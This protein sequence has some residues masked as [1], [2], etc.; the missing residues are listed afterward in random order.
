MNIHARRIPACIV[1][2]HTAFLCAVAPQTLFANHNAHLVK[3]IIIIGCRYHRLCCKIVISVICIRIVARPAFRTVRITGIR[4][5][6]IRNCL[7]IKTA[8][9]HQVYHLF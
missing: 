9:I 3:K 7:R 2:N 1:I 6:Y 4:F 8:G 5:A